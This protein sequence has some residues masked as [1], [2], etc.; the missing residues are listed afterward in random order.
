MNDKTPGPQFEWVTIPARRIYVAVG[1]LAALVIIS[2]GVYLWLHRAAPPPA[3]QDAQAAEAAL[4]GS[5]EGSVKIIRAGTREIVFAD[6]GTRLQPGDTVQT[7][8]TGRVNVVLA[9]GSTLVVRPNSVVT[10]SENAGAVGGSAPHVRVA[11]EGGQ[12]NVSTVQQTPQTSNIVE[13]P[14]AGNSLHART[15]AS[16][17]VHTDKS[18]EVR[19]SAGVVERRTVN[20]QTDLRAGEY[21]AFGQ[22][23]EVKQREQ[24][25]DTPVPYEPP[26]R[27]SLPTHA[28]SA[29]VVLQWTRPQ[30]SI[31]ATYRVEIAASP[32][33]VKLG[34]VFERDRL[35]A[36]KLSVTE[37]KPG[38]YFWRVRAE[39]T[40]GQLS[41]WCEPQKFAIVPEEKTG[42]A[43]AP[44]NRR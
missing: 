41:E 15:A 35:S 4:L 5:F 6:A 26:D 42:D 17:D 19:V 14:L 36:L 37:L 25:L 39:A 38:N 32:F 18:E 20:N 9:D 7:E 29:N 40:G 3:H 12:V 28:G 21:V 11:I 33:F 23:G 13:T 2:V 1:L 34:M 8:A 24:L 44:R 10:I 30:A 27:A 43:G 16:F 31:P 22:S